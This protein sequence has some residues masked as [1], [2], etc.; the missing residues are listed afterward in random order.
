MSELTPPSNWDV[1]TVILVLR[2]TPDKK[3]SLDLDL[4]MLILYNKKF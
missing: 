4:K 3:C 1:E 2:Q